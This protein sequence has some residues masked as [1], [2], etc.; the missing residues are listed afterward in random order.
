MEETKKTSDPSP[1]N[2]NQTLKQ[3]SDG[4]SV[5]K[6]IDTRKDSVDAEHDT[7]K[8]SKE[9]TP[10]RAHARVWEFIT[11]PEHANA[12]M[13]IFTVLIFLATLGY[14][15]VALKQWSAMKD[16][17]RIS[18]ESLESVQRAF[19][20]PLNISARKVQEGPGVFLWGFTPHLENSG[21]TPAVNA[22][23]SYC[24]DR[25]GGEPGENDFEGPKNF[26][27]A[28]ITIGPKAAPKLKELM[29]TE[30][31][32]F[33]QEIGTN[34]TPGMIKKGPESLFVWGWVMYND[35]FPNTKIH[36][37]EFCESMGAISSLPDG[38]AISIT[39]YSCAHHNCTDE[40][41]EDYEQMV[42]NF[43]RK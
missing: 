9:P 29:V 38:K 22:I 34:P 26:E 21:T 18:R 2:A 27:R 12:I 1:G 13:A 30:K 24:A 28:P 11:K 7:G 36:L 25:L 31:T 41:C 37:T 10:L 16:S 3:H 43:G 6:R 15:W 17:N 4:T 8:S 35:V 32:A 14:A 19:I 33:G 40:Y 42:K 5:A 20:T 23:N 39:Y